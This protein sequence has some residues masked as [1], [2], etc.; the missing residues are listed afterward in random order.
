MLIR[1]YLAIPPYFK[2]FVPDGRMEGT[3]LTTQCWPH[4]NSLETEAQKGMEQPAQ[5]PWVRGSTG[6]DPASSPRC[7]E[8]PVPGPYPWILA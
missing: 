3:P 8:L 5:S 1:K 4:P 6:W 2:A 7:M